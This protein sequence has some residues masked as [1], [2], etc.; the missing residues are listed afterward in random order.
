MLIGPKG[1]HF[2]IDKQ[3]G[4]PFALLRTII[5]VRSVDMDIAN[6]DRLK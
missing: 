1:P 3:A 6:G 5:Y 2:E 4:I